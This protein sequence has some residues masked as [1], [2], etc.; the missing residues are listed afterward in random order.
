M[1]DKAEGVTQPADAQ[2]RSRDFA[3]AVVERRRKFSLVWLVPVVAAAIGIWLVIVGIHE[4]GP[5][6][7]VSFQTAGGL[8]AGKTKVK[9]RDVEI[10]QLQNLSLS[11][12]RRSVVATI[13]IAKSAAPY[14]TDTTKFWVVR[15]RLDASGISGLGTLISGAYIEI[16]PGAPGKKADHYTGLEEPPVVTTDTPG[17]RFVLRSDSAESLNARDPIYFRGIQVGQILGYALSDDRTTFNFIAFVKAPYDRLVG[18]TSHFWRSGGI[19]VNAGADGFKM[20]IGSLASLLQGGIEFDT[21]ANPA[22][23][24]QAKENQVFQLFASKDAVGESTIA[25]KVPYVLYFDGSV[26]GLTVGAPVEFRGIRVGTV[27][28]IRPQVDMARNAVRIAVEINLEPDRV[29]PSAD[30]QGN[31]ST[32]YELMPALVKRGLRAQMETAS[33]LTG[34]KLIELDFH[35]GEPD[36]SVNFAG[37]VP[38]IPTVPPA[39]DAITNSIDRILKRVE[40]LPL[41]S[42]TA[43]LQTSIV[44]LDETLKETKTLVRTTNKNLDPMVGDFR[45]AANS[46]QQALQEIQRTSA[47]MDNSFGDS[48]E[49]RMRLAQALREFQSSARSLRE[50]TDMLERNPEALVRG[51]N[52]A[53][54]P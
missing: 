23:Q 36:A 25:E 52:A 15:P 48:S 11:D 20:R 19:E 40:S 22:T 26:R 6:V 35:P 1:A 44:S 21:S 2:D 9:Y 29:L 38:E 54:A 39:L 45:A 28:G 51:K 5:V 49:V 32:R 3:E 24:E 41:D 42:L 18:E 46:A 12:D 37:A 14:L 4:K 34:Q 47:S 43:D 33:L 31:A 53:A 8:E 16:E 13:D 27:A 50:L 7:T 10:G 30:V 17:R